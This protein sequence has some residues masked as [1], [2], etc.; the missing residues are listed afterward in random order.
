MH[1]K[2]FLLICTASTFFFITIHLGAF[3]A[4]SSPS[5][6]KPDIQQLA[7]NN[8]K[9]SA[10]AKDEKKGKD[11]VK[12]KTVK[13]VGTTAVVGVAG[14]KVKSGAKGKVTQDKE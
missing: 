12:K 6:S 13:K 8:V 14:K 1:N 10:G 4:C 11:S 9:N 2:K 7:D 5:D 3:P